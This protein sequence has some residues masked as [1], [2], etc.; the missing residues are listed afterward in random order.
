[1]DKLLST[2]AILLL[3]GL[4][5][6]AATQ[7]ADEEEP[8]PWSGNLS[9]GYLESS[10]N[11]DSSSATVEFSIMYATGAWKH[12]F[13]GR[14]FSSSDSNVTTAESYSAGLKSTWNFTD[15]DYLFGAIDWNKDRF[16]G[17]DQ[18]TFLTAGYGRTVLDSKKFS[19]SL[20]I[21]AGY[22]QQDLVNGISENNATGRASGSFVW[23]ISENA[24]F[25]QSLTSFFTSDNTFVE[26]I[27][28]VT[29]GLIGNVGL[30]FNYTVR[31]NS[32]VLPGIQNTDRFTTLALR[33][34]F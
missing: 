25:E 19:L 24:S 15:I 9:L 5:G 34:E 14:A 21:G 13:A 18:Q 6:F 16:S 8:G 22:S 11:S 4:P 1:M 29:A 27:S 10:G 2:I 33:Y 31:R 26:S 7:D 32:D 17:Y 12:R 28:E 3:L 20:E 30:T 23:N